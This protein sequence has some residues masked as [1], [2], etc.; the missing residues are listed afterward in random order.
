MFY[1][2]IPATSGPRSDARAASAE[3][4]AIFA[5]IRPSTAQASSFGA[6]PGCVRMRSPMR[7]KDQEG[8]GNRFWHTVTGQKPCEFIRCA[9]CRCPSKARALRSLGSEKVCRGHFSFFSRHQITKQVYQNPE[10][11]NNPMLGLCFG[12]VLAC[13]HTEKK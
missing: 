11:F 13:E 1:G 7:W 5:R 3:H 2:Y 10:D 4:A 9:R 8:V 6:R 12:G